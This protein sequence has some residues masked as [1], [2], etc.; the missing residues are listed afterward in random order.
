M[1]LYNMPGSAS[2]RDLQFVGRGA[3][4]AVLEHAGMGTVANVRAAD[5][6]DVSEA[7]PL[8]RLWRSIQE[9]KDDDD[10]KMVVD[11]KRVVRAAYHAILQIQYAE[12]VAGSEIPAAFQCPISH[13]WMTD[14]VV[15]VPSGISYE[16]VHL[17]RWLAG[18]PSP[19]VQDPM[20]RG[21][22]TWNAIQH[23]RPLEERFLIRNLT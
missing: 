17:Q 2:V 20:A 12:P 1:P 19:D 22:V 14:P 18:A 5:L 23:Y 21:A 3:C 15:A 9:I 16:A 8:K 4:A 13:E 6:D 11:W 7:G 10:Y